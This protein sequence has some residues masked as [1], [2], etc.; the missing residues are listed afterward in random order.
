M[1]R[2]FFSWYNPNTAASPVK[3]SPKKLP[4]PASEEGDDEPPPSPLAHKSK[5]ARPILTKS[6]ATELMDVDD[7]TSTIKDETEAFNFTV[8]PMAISS[9]PSTPVGDKG[10][11]SLNELTNEAPADL[12][13]PFT[14]SIRRIL[15]KGAM[16]GANP[17]PPL[18]DGL[19]VSIL[20]SRLE[21]KKVKGAFLTPKEMEDL[22]ECWKPYRSL[23]VYFMWRLAEEPKKG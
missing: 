10:T 23:G 16:E 11:V 3:L 14:P 18:P 5:I 21:G 8:P 13:P 6:Q 1:V 7:L 19:S 22:T 12:P 4:K 2:W 15:A 9:R 20:K 17:P